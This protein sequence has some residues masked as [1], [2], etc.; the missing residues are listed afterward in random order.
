MSCEGTVSRLGDKMIA[1][2]EERPVAELMRFSG[3]GRRA[4]SLAI[5]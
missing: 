1:K 2:E 5:R 3:Q 4:K